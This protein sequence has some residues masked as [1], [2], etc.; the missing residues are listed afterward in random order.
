MVFRERGYSDEEEEGEFS[1]VEEADDM[2]YGAPAPR[3]T[4]RQLTFN[5]ADLSYTKL[6]RSRD[7]SFMERERERQSYMRSKANDRDSDSE[8]ENAAAKRKGS[9]GKLAVSAGLCL[10]A[11]RIETIFK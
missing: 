1:S 11:I 10:A 2:T 3:R 5:K 9:R 4:H 6:S 7:L 8:L